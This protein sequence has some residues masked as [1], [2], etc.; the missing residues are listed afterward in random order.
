MRSIKTF[1][2]A[3]LLAALLASPAQG[4]DLTLLNVSYDPT[5]ELYQEVNWAFA[6]AWKEKTRNLNLESRDGFTPD[7]RFFIGFAQW[8]CDNERDENKRV[9][10][11]TDP[12]SP[13]R[14]RVN[15]LVVNMPEFGQ[16]FACK[17]GDAMVK[18]KEKVC[19]IW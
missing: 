15:G 10:A 16:A 6:E 3:G 9:S 14:Y 12:H 1:I 8:A 2:A 17:A 19:R 13:P 18:P 7:Q 5:R 4:E 11:V